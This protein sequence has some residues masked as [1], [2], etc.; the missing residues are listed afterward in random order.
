MS[1]A[2]QRQAVLDTIVALADQ[3]ARTSPECSDLAMQ[4][5]KLVHELGAEADRTLLK[6]TIDEETTDTDVSDALVQATADAVMRA[7]RTDP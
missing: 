2:S 7:V 6:Y 3:I 1:T 5:V 4:I